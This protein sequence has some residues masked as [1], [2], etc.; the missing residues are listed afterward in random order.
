MTED[1]KQGELDNT[2]DGD[3]PVGEVAAALEAEA[4]EAV[5]AA[6]EEILEAAED[7]YGDEDPV[8]QWEGA[9][10]DAHG[11]GLA[12]KAWW[13]LVHKEQMT[14]LFANLLFF[15]GVL[16]AWS[17]AVP[18][19]A[20]NPANHIHGLD[21]VRGAL[22]FALALYGFVIIYVNIRF[23]QTR[24]L[25]IFMNALFALWVGIPGFTRMIGSAEWDQAK[26]HVEHLK[27]TVGG[28]SILDDFLIPLSAI[29]PGYWM[30]TAGGLL[31][32][33]V[34]VRGVL[35]GASSVKAQKR[36]AAGSRRRRS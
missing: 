10:A 14:L 15:V 29:A 24:V 17:R 32:L 27:Q 34:L 31:V 20:A 26:A 3:E 22:I 5:Q 13:S 11:E 9:L 1:T 28:V 35:A 36:E 25:P 21:T 19:D 18:G 4:A 23:R 30:L 33:L 7:F 8:V 16:A 6:E 2:P 12:A